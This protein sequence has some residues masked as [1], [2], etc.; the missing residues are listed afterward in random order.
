MARNALY[1]QSGGPT[2]V[3][4][5]TAYGVINACKAYPQQIKRL[6]GVKYGM[7]GLLA[8]D[9]IDIYA[10]EQ[11]QIDLLPQTPSMIFG[12]C[13]YRIADADVDDRDYQTIMSMLKKHDIGFI[14]MNGGNGTAHAFLALNEY[15]SRENYDCHMIMIPKTVDNDIEGIDHSPG[16]PS[17]ARHVIISLSELAHDVRTYNTGLITVVEVMGRNTGWLVA[18]T[19]VA[20]K[21]GNGPDL[22]YVPEVGFSQ[23]KFLADVEEVYRRKNKCIAVVAEGVKDPHGKYLFEYGAEETENPQL[24]MGGITPY[25][26]SLLRR[27]F[28]CKVRGIDLGLMQRCA[29]H[30]ASQLDIEEAIALGSRAVMSALNGVNAKMVSIKRVS[31]RPYRVED[32]LV[33]VND[34]VEKE[35]RLPL[36]YVATE[37]NYINSTYLDYIEPLVGEMPT[38]A[39]L[40]LRG[41]GDNYVSL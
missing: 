34:V 19:I 6:Y 8:G 31:N 40:E 35:H 20:Q 16:F 12:S 32:V 7:V 38:Y 10:E 14:F 37:G 41:I 26:S 9:L 25:L 13:R 29:I 2:S 15:L 5:A 39:S 21:D 36:N 11:H 3:I 18:S 27:N 4:N 30:T 23:E 17:T 24:N 1:I 28:D 33:D 22:I